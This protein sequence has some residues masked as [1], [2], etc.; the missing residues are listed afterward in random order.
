MLTI[1]YDVGCLVVLI[2]I[3]AL[4]MAVRDVGGPRR[5]CRALCLLVW[6]WLVVWWGWGRPPQGWLMAYELSVL[7]LMAVGCAFLWVLSAPPAKPTPEPV[8]T[9]AETPAHEGPKINGQYRSE[10]S[11][12][13]DVLRSKYRK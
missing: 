5:M 3:A 13:E 6:S 7:L 12:V 9:P 8:E 4:C 10:S 11:V 2:L 1:A